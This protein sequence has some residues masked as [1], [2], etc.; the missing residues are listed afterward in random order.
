MSAVMVVSNFSFLLSFN[1]HQRAVK[2]HHAVVAVPSDALLT[3]F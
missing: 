2:L 1:D 3:V